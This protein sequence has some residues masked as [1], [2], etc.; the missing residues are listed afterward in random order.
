M[1]ITQAPQSI[2]FA[3]PA[4]PVTYGVSPISLSAS[5]S[6]GLGVSF[7]VLSGPATVSGNILTIT[8]AGTVIVA[9]NQPGNADYLAAPQVTTTIVVN[10]ATPTLT[11]ATPAAITYG[12]PLSGVQL[13]ATSGGVAGSFAYAPPSGTVLSAGTHTL[14]VTFTPSD[15]VDY[16]NQTASVSLTV[17]QATAGVSVS[18]SPNPITYGSQTTT[19]TTTVGGSATGTVA[20]TING[21]AW[22]SRICGWFLHDQSHI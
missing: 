15:S 7:S 14:S 21:S 4:S 16:N 10:K 8:G 19:C 9:A 12:T 1:T 17:N 22:T 6:S 11:W 13:D 5:T 20:W 2:T 3:P 18:C